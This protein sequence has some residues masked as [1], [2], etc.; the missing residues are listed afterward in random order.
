MD[1]TKIKRR[2]YL[3]VRRIFHSTFIFDIVKKGEPN[4]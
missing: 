2:L 3:T 1:P 4:D